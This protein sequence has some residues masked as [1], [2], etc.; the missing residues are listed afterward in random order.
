MSKPPGLIDF[1]DRTYIVNL[2]SRIDRKNETIEEFNRYEF[3]INNNK[4]DFFS[5]IKPDDTGGFPNIGTRGC[6]LSHLAIIE[7]AIQTNLE[8]ILIIED[9]IYFSR[10]IHKYTQDALDGLNKLEWDIA[11]LGHPLGDDQ[12]KP[13]WKLLDQPMMMSHFYAL[14]AKTFK[15]LAKFLRA[16]ENRPLGDPE[17]GPMHYDGAL[18]FYREKHPEVNAYYF[19]KNLGWQ[20]PSKTDIHENSFL[21]RYHLLKPATKIIRNLKTRFAKEYRF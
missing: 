20:R 1:F 7:S 5:A 14:N 4:C 13:S 6:F 16:V 21:D 8:T 2:P 19:S 11:Y 9:D 15:K 3:P 17:G 12:K 18:N 10:K